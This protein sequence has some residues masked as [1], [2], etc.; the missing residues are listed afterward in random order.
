M[1]LAAPRALFTRAGAMMRSASIR[2][3]LIML[4]GRRLRY[5][6]AISITA[7]SV[8]PPL[9]FFHAIFLLR[10]AMPTP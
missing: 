7:A 5:A 3:R 2:V 4:D 8:M 6:A 9:M 10:D 1:M